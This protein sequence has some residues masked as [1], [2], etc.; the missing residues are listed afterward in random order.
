M[1]WCF[2]FS[3]IF[4][5]TLTPKFCHIELTRVRSEVYDPLKISIKSRRYK[6]HGLRNRRGIQTDCDP[7]ERHV[8]K[9][10][11]MANSLLLPLPWRT[12]HRDVSREPQ[13]QLTLTRTL[14]M[15]C[16]ALLP[17]ALRL[18]LMKSCLLRHNH[19]H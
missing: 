17:L 19:V 8:K 15:R 12:L 10:A 13:P 7:Q 9:T 6:Y 2:C 14:Q 11:A 1:F 18:I 16:S 3:I 4:T 5:L